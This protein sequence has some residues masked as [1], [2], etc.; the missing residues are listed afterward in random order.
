MYVLDGSRNDLA[1]E[2]LAKPYG[3]H[4]PELKVALS[5][6]IAMREPVQESVLNLKLS[7]VPGE[8]STDEMKTL[9]SFLPP[10]PKGAKPDTPRTIS[11]TLARP[12][13]R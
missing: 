3:I 5:G 12:R 4:S 1:S 8:N 2:F 9:L 13:V 10:P 6:Q 7:A 11:G